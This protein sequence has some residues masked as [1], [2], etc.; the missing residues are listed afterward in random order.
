MIVVRFKF[1]AQNSNLVRRYEMS[2]E[3]LVTAPVVRRADYRF[4]LIIV[5]RSHFL[6]KELTQVKL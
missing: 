3:H 1:P 4:K 6:T 5:F 2:R